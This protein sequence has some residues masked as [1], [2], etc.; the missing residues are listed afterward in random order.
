MLVL[1]AILAEAAVGEDFEP[2]RNRYECKGQQYRYTFAINTFAPR[3]VSP[4]WFS[5]RVV[6]LRW[7]DLRSGEAPLRTTPGRMVAFDTVTTNPWLARVKA[8][9]EPHPFSVFRDKELLS[10]DEVVED[11]D[12]ILAAIG[13]REAHPFVAHPV[14]FFFNTV[15]SD[16]KSEVGRTFYGTPGP[17]VLEKAPLLYENSSLQRGFVDHWGWCDLDAPA[18]LIQMQHDHTRRWNAYFEFVHTPPGREALYFVAPQSPITTEQLESRLDTFDIA[19]QP[20]HYLDYYLLTG[21]SRALGLA[22]RGLEWIIDNQFRDGTM[23]HEVRPWD[24]RSIKTDFLFE[25]IYYPAQAIAM[26]CYVFARQEPEFSRRLEAC[27]SRFY[28]YLSRECAS[29]CYKNNP[30]HTGFVLDALQWRYY[31]TRGTRERDDL[32]FIA[33]ALAGWNWRP[34]LPDLAAYSA[35]FLKGLG[36]VGQIL[37]PETFRPLAEEYVREYLLPSIFLNRCYGYSFPKWKADQDALYTYRSAEGML[38]WFLASRDP[39]FL[40]AGAYEYADFYPGPG[41]ENR[42]EPVFP[43]SKWRQHWGSSSCEDGMRIIGLMRWQQRIPLLHE[44]MRAIAKAE[45]RKTGKQGE[46]ST[47][48]IVGI[49]KLSWGPRTALEAQ[50]IAGEGEQ[51]WDMVAQKRVERAELRGVYYR[52]GGGPLVLRQ[53][54][55][56]SS[57]FGLNDQ[58][59]PVLRTM[60]SAPTANYLVHL[61]PETSLAQTQ[62]VSMNEQGDGFVDLNVSFPVV[63]TPVDILLSGFKQEK[64][65]SEINPIDGAELVWIPGGEFFMGTDAGDIPR[66]LEFAQSWDKNV[67]ADSFRNQS[68]RHKVMVGGFWI[69]KYEVT[70]EQL[71]R[72]VKATGYQPQYGKEGREYWDKFTEGGKANHPAVC[73]SWND[74]MAYCKWAGGRLPTEAEWEYAARGADG[75]RFP[76]GNDWSHHNCNYADKNTPFPH[77]DKTADDGFQYTAPVGSFPQ[78]A[79]PFGAM[80]MAGNVWEW[81][82]SLYQPYPYNATDGRENLSGT[83]GDRVLRGG[84]WYYRPSDCDAA[85]RFWLSPDF[86]HYGIGVR[87]VV[88][89]KD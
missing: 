78:G 38:D 4:D 49:G 1:L 74:A 20:A 42:R 10:E 29:G 68:P 57:F 51:L 5:G 72:F 55:A 73:V 13:R 63:G 80:D 9:Y 31:L 37:G 60:G 35:G 56:C 6:G 86:K 54:P 79:S 71:D 45:I 44:L 11:N 88:P 70:N 83:K 50:L 48:E 17:E 76:W 34:H 22:R 12:V 33:R 18:A 21:D 69:Y 3:G 25:D 26:G 46:D 67:N 30:L 65:K 36:I 58:G 32:A 61:P 64:M 87:C 15:E 89:K 84:A 40:A 47:V 43:D 14:V 27:W 19:R 8:I 52:L 16:I 81:C 75:R 7:G 77:S 24:K 39:F 53:S 59:Q 85:Y 2:L 23:P 62:G 28:S 82:S 66:L 41:N